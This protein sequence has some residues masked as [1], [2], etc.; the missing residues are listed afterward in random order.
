MA[1]SSG[2]YGQRKRIAEIE[3]IIKQVPTDQQVQEELFLRAVTEKFVQVPEV[4]SLI[5]RQWR[6]SLEA[7][8]EKEQARIRQQVTKHLEKFLREEAPA[9][10][11]ELRIG[12]EL[13]KLN[14]EAEKIIKGEQ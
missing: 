14:T 1:K 2:G 12:E 7:G 11:S 8:T 10:L 5:H 3:D 4:R 9:I 6:L 13:E